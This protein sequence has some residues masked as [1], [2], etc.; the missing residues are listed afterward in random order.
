[1]RHSDTRLLALD[2]GT[3]LLRA[4]RLGPGG[5][6]L[7]TRQLSRGVAAIAGDRPSFERTFD[8]ACGDWVS[9]SPSA[10]VIACGMVGSAQGWREA[11]YREVPSSLIDPASAL[12][13][14]ETAAGTTV[15]I[16]PGLLQ[17]GRLPDV[18]RGE[19]TQ[20]AGALADP[21][22][23]ADDATTL[24]G[25]PGTHSKW[26]HIRAGRIVRFDTFMTGELF[27]ALSAH[28]L[29]AR[30]L[31]RGPGWDLDAFDAGA[32]VARSAEGRAG[33][34]ANVFSTRT[35]GLT[36]ALSPE[37]QAD[38]LSGLLIGHELGGLERLDRHTFDGAG[39]VLLAGTAA[40]SRRYQRVLATFGR[41]DVD[42]A[43]GAAERGLWRLAVAARLVDEPPA[44]RARHRL[45]AALAGSGLVAILR[46][47]HPREATEVGAAL[48]AAGLR[49]VEVPLHS[50]EPFASIRA[51]RAALPIDCAVGA[52]TVT[53][54]AEMEEVR[55]A[56]GE[57]AVMPHADPRLIR[58]A[59]SA[60]LEVAPGVATISEALAALAAGAD[61]LKMF[62]ADQLGA[63][64]LAAWRAVLPR[65][66]PV[67]PVGGITP[68]SLPAFIAAG[69][70]GF[71]VG[72]AI[73]RSGRATGE[74][75]ARA[76]D[77]A[78]AWRA[79]VDGARGS[80]RAM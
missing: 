77:F 60:G 53:S 73:Y 72:S 25:L 46:G 37:A 27:E 48:V 35:L 21:P 39:R 2:W 50:P 44:E 10:P 52:G 23:G 41:A 7:E 34:L 18:M 58:A 61:V 66:T 70:A 45:R 26:A 11:G 76:A 20:I 42:L 54:A 78:A 67:V 71:G 69:A 9:A 16:V 56:G 8:E 12:T 33:L 75:A 6:L 1:V 29:L 49:A 30:T 63:E 36:G 59:R 57:F 19:E 28:T 4:H 24:V 74:V 32:A 80:G 31:V 14:V 79:V 62:P 55:D 68:D 15:H 5:V 51:L 17:R 43:G 3:T 64:T 38:Y 13:P 22:P 47:V 40:L 65:G